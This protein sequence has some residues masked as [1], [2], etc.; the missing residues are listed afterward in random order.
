MPASNSSARHEHLEPVG[1]MAL[2]P[3][4]SERKRT[5]SVDSKAPKKSGTEPVGKK[6][7]PKTKHLD[8]PEKLAKTSKTAAA[9]S[10]VP[11]TMDPAG[12]EE[13][14]TPPPP[15]TPSLQFGSESPGSQMAFP[16]LSVS[17]LELAK[18]MF[19]PPVPSA[20]NQPSTSAQALGS[21]PFQQSMGPQAWWPQQWP[22]QASAPWNPYGAPWFPT[23]Y[24]QQPVSWSA[25]FQAP[26]PVPGPA[27]DSR[28]SIQGSGS[29]SD[30]DS[31][32]LRSDPGSEAPSD[33]SPD[34]AF[35]GLPLSPNEDPRGFADQMLR[36]ARSLEVDIAS[37]ALKPKE[38]ILAPIYSDAPLTVALPVLSDFMDNA[39]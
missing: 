34:E 26:P 33:S 30:K 8:K 19:L 29:D 35:C 31:V 21:I 1:S 14:G 18:S 22:M 16:E 11:S 28:F 13:S 2:D 17:D 7:K 23:P 12:L 25:P 4:V 39:K 37:S 38:K 9:A 3:P 27:G 32:P 20:P 10:S 36:L 6:A 15:R 24:Q 5:A